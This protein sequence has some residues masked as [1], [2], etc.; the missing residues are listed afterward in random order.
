MCLF[1]IQLLFRGCGRVRQ[2]LA[3]DRKKKLLL[4]FSNL[5]YASR[6]FNNVQY[7]CVMCIRAD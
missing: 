4:R 7:A 3:F 5:Y 2:I 6:S 1:S